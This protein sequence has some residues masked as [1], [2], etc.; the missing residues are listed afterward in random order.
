MYVHIHIHLCVCGGGK[1]HAITLKDGTLNAGQRVRGQCNWDSSY[2]TQHPVTSGGPQKDD[3]CKPCKPGWPVWPSV[4]W[5]RGHMGGRT[6]HS[7]VS[8]LLGASG[9]GRRHTWPQ[10]L[11]TVLSDSHPTCAFWPA[12]PLRDVHIFQVVPCL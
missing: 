11:C 9:D 6:G 7:P 12:F 8:A 2:P 3:A 4:S 1:H 5:G 10:F